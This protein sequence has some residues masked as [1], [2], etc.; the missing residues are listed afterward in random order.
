MRILDK[1]GYIRWKWNNRKKYL[2]SYSQ[3]GEDTIVWFILKHF[4]KLEKIRY[5]D[6]GAHHS[7]KL[8][9]T[10]LLYDKRC[11]GVLIEP[12]P[13]LYKEI[14]RHR[15]RDICL[16][17]GVGLSDEKMA[18]FYIMKARTL[19]TFSKDEAQ[20]LEEKNLTAIEKIVKIDLISI[21]EILDKYF[22]DGLD[23]MSLDIEGIDFDVLKSI[24]WEKIRPKV[25]CVET[26]TYDTI[27]KQKK[28]KN[29]IEYMQMQGYF[30]YADTYINT[31]FVDKKFW[32][33]C[34]K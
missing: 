30:V 29:I 15:K 18:D 4:M 1:L 27:D 16:N 26:I 7:Q 25:I 10:K 11:E 19:N 34:G 32:E 23:F 28:E 9:N 8:S 31:I 12:D 20:K 33:Q 22:L 13:E 5:I 14:K 6:I 3:C 2:K 24:E 17:C 21:N